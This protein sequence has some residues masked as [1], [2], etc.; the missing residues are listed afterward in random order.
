MFD[1][2]DNC[3]ILSILSIKMITGGQMNDENCIHLNNNTNHYHHH[4]HHYHRTI[5]GQ[6]INLSFQRNN[7][8]WPLTGTGIAILTRP[9]ILI[10]IIKLLLV[11]ANYANKLML[12]NHSESEIISIFNYPQAETSQEL[13]S[14]SLTN[15]LQFS[16]EPRIQ[17]S[18]FL[19]AFNLLFFLLFFLS[20]LIEFDLIRLLFSDPIPMIYCLLKN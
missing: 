17:N 10:I 14:T 19:A 6:D 5:N 1:I 4:H 7:R 2:I 11:P 9:I 8:P 15:G 13:H 16:G 3:A 12:N 18:N 20:F